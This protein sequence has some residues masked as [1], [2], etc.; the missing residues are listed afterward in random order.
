MRRSA[1]AVVAAVALA[2]C[3]PGQVTWW[4]TT[5]DRARA[6]GVNCPDLAPAL[7]LAGLPARF[8]Q[9]VWRES[10]CTPTVVN[11][12][13][14]AL[15]LTQIMPQWIAALCGQHIACSRAQ[16]LD[17]DTNLA[18]AAYVFQIQGWQAWAT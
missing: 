11:A 12:G 5:V 7:E 9:I 16:L 14:G 10:R 2:G 1:A 13:T 17:V 6:G 15:G 8:D 3:T 18:A 4:A